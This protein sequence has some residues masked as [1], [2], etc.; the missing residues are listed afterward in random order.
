MTDSVVGFIHVRDV[1]DRMEDEQIE[2]LQA[3][4]EANRKCGANE[5]TMDDDRDD[6]D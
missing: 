5:H 1:R 4:L 3:I 6:E 2:E